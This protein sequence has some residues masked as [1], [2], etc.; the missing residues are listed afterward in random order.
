MIVKEIKVSFLAGTEVKDAAWQMY[1]M[2]IEK[3]AK[4]ITSFN[5]LIVTIQPEERKLKHGNLCNS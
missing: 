5:G 2:A 1:Q 3:K 4:I